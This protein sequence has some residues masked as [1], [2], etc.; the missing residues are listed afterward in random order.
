[1]DNIIILIGKSCSGK[2]VI[3]KE[4]EKL[5]AKRGISYTTRPMRPC[6]KNG[7]DYFFI[8]DEE[9]DVL[10]KNS[11]L[12]ESTSYLVKGQIWRYGLGEG[13][14]S[15]GLNVC[16]VNPEGANLI[17][18]NKDIK[19]KAIIF[20]LEAKIST[21]VKRYINRDNGLPDERYRELVERIIQ[22]E[23]DFE[24]LRNL[25][26][27]TDFYSLKNELMGGYPQ[28]SKR[29]IEIVEYLKNKGEKNG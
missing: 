9:F 28:V 7:I 19:G 6:E 2:S 1:M 8:S 22:D 27:T 21:R 11:K 25:W 23:K 16:T 4:L 18:K 29:I 20:H 15:S 13:S 26:E 5:G 10:L 24:D 14:F 12:Y 17:L 3:E